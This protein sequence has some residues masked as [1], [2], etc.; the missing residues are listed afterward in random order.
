LNVFIVNVTIFKQSYM[1]ILWAIHTNA[2]H[3]SMFSLSVFCGGVCLIISSFGGA[4]A[5]WP[6]I[7]ADLFGTKHVGI[8]QVEKMTVL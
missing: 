2:L 4:A 8:I 6:A 1:G 3:P 7:T 5:T